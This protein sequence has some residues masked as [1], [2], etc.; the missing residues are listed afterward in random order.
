MDDIDG[1]KIGL[2]EDHAGSAGAH[3]DTLDFAD[4]SETNLELESSWYEKPHDIERL[5]A[6]IEKLEEPDLISVVKIILENRTPE[7]YIETNVEGYLPLKDF[8]LIS[9]RGI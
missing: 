6:A 3:P 2:R 1:D 8:V 9:R 7:M 5:A 4:I